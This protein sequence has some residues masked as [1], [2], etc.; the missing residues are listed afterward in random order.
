MNYLIKNHLRKKG[1]FGTIWKYANDADTHTVETHIYRL[2]KK[3][4]TLLM[5]KHLSK[6]REKVIDLKKRN[7]YAKDLM[8]TK[9]RVRV[10]NPKG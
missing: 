8:S 3:S 6:V 2:R 7:K 10:V 9:Y 4:K 1:N 5:M